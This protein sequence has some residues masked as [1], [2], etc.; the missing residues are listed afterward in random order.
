[1]NYPNTLD[2]ISRASAHC[3]KSRAMLKAQRLEI[4][5][6]RQGR[7]SPKAAGSAVFSLD[8]SMAF[9]LVSQDYLIAALKFAQVEE[10]LINVVLALQRSKYLVGH[11]GHEG[12]INL[13]NGIRQG[14]ALSPLLWV[15]ATNYMLHQLSNT[16]GTEWI[17]EGVTAFADDFLTAFRVQSK[18]DADLMQKRILGLLQVLQQAGMQV[19]PEKSS[20]LLRFTGSQLKKWLKSRTKQVQGK[21]HLSLG[22]PFKPVDIPMTQSLDY[23]GITL[24]K[25][26]FED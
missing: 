22:T 14:C 23:L 18:Q 24:S 5:D 3:A 12:T 4:Q 8:M 19:N 1:M 26:C 2:A 25:G 11:H 17:R 20:I 21:Q 9:D 10:D 16:T 13:Q 15:F 6:K 7:T